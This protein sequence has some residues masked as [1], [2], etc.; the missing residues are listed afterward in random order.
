MY[1]FIHGTMDPLYKR[2]HFI[3]SM[4][5]VYT[6]LLRIWSHTAKILPQNTY[7]IVSPKAIPFIYKDRGFKMLR[8]KL[9]N[10]VFQIL[11]LLIRFSECDMSSLV[12]SNIVWNIITVNIAFWVFMDH[13]LGRRIMC[14][15]GKYITRVNIY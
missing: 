10:N 8:Y 3:Y 14:R 5:K 11:S 9:R 2:Y 15:K 6:T 1:L 12:R 13:N 7:F 4:L